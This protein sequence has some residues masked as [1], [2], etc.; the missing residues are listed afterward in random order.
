MEEELQ[1]P[2]PIGPF[3]RFADENAWLTAARAAGFMTTVTDE[4][5]NET[6]QLKAYTHDYALDVI[7]SITVGGE[8]DE[9]GNVI[10]EP[11]V[12]DGWHVN[13]RGE[14]PD[15]WLQYAVSPE[16]PVRV[17]A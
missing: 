8:W 9:E 2:P 15:E 16:Q 1:L 13:Y 10:T 11:T 5:G 14:V 12:L 3:F 6:E 7:G 17:W 4:E